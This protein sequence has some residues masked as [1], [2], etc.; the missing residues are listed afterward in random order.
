MVK[1]TKMPIAKLVLD[2]AF[3]PRT[4][5]D[6]QR[7]SKYADAWRANESFPPVVVS[8][9]DW[10]VI[11]GF[12]RIRGLEKAL[13]KEA[14]IEVEVRDYKT[15]ADRYMD[16]VALNARHG[17]SLNSLDLARCIILAKDFGIEEEKFR[18]AAGITEAKHE[19]LVKQKLAERKDGTSIP[20]KR[21]FAQFAGTQVSKKIEQANDRA[22]GLP[23]RWYVDQLLNI[24]DSG[25]LD[26]ADEELMR[27][28]EKLRAA[29]DKIAQPV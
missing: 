24:I 27:K 6:E 20:I 11:D 15:D 13:G 3:Y 28:I 23:Q 29:L 22:S 26:V 19:R 2:F 21:T 16:S 8:R 14:T 12:H 7:V 1:T 9:G 18:L 5:I 10:R 17:L 25:G 4:S